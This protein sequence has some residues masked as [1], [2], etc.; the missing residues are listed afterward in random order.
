MENK[1]QNASATKQNNPAP[2]PAMA[3]TQEV[4]IAKAP[5]RSTSNDRSELRLNL[6]EAEAGMVRNRKNNTDVFYVAQNVIDQFKEAGWSLEWKRHTVYGAED[7]SYEIALKDNG[8]EPVTADELPHY[9]PDDY[10]GAIIRDGLQLMKRPQYLTDESR[11]E[12]RMAAQAAINGN[13]AKLGQ[14]PNPE[15]NRNNPNV[16]PRVTKSFERM[17]IPEA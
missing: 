10:K 6:R 12:E 5:L 3:E 8:W 11:R 15:F 2:A 14:S 7:R 1:S 13:L 9:M 17:E 16:K 4:R